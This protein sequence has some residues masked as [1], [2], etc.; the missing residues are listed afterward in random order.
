[1]TPASTS[2]NEGKQSPAEAAVPAP[3]AP[4]EEELKNRAK[5][6]LV[7]M[8][9]LLP[10]ASKAL[11]DITITSSMTV[12]EVVIAAVGKLTTSPAGNE[13]G[14]QN[15]ID[16]T[17][18][19]DEIQRAIKESQQSYQVE[20]DKREQNL[21]VQS[22]Q[23][24]PPNTKSNG[25]AQTSTEEENLNKAIQLSLQ[26]SSLRISPLCD[27]M[28]LSRKPNMPVGL[29][30]TGN[31]CYFNSIVQVLFNSHKGLRDAILDFPAEYRPLPSPRS[32]NVPNQGAA[33]PID[34][35]STREK[36]T[37][38]RR[39]QASEA[40]TP[41]GKD[42]QRAIQEKARSPNTGTDKDS[43]NEAKTKAAVAF[44]SELQRAFVYLIHSKRKFYDPRPAVNALL[45]FCQGSLKEGLQHDVAEIMR[46]IVE[47]LDIAFK[48]KDYMKDEIEKLFY[49]AGE[50][51]ITANDRKGKTDPTTKQD[52]KI[53]DVIVD[54]DA[55]E[56]HAALERYTVRAIEQFRLPDG[57]TLPARTEIW[58]KRIPEMLCI[59]INRAA[60][61]A[62][63]KQPTKLHT[64]FNFPKQLYMDRYLRNKKN[65]ASELR[66]EHARLLRQ[67]DNLNSEMREYTQYK[68]GNG[69]DSCGPL[70][71][72]EAVRATLHFIQKSG[73]GTLTETS[74]NQA[75]LQV[76]GSRASNGATSQT[77]DHK[78]N[79][80]TI[81]PKWISGGS[82]R[83][84][85]ANP[86]RQTPVIATL[87]DALKRIRNETEKLEK[88]IKDIEGCIETLYAPIESEPYELTA[89]MVHEGRNASQGHYWTYVDTDKCT[90]MPTPYFAKDGFGETEMVVEGSK[91]ISG[92]D[93]KK[94]GHSSSS[95]KE[96]SWIKFND[97]NV[98]K[99]NEEDVFNESFGGHLNASAYCLVYTSCASQYRVPGAKSDIKHHVDT[100][101]SS[102][103]R[104]TFTRYYE[105]V[106]K[107]NEDF[108]KS[109]ESSRKR[110]NPSTKVEAS[111]LRK[112]SDDS[113]TAQRATPEEKTQN[114]AKRRRLD[115]AGTADI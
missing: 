26:S 8:G 15:Q 38:P 49:A 72:D 32:S 68:F 1:M 101:W 111:N 64:K 31:I 59:Q 46:D 45:Q 36:T 76:E 65:K 37:P 61:D 20:Q 52:I 21:R 53:G 98:S 14:K 54:V 82:Q 4:N 24:P 96:S 55:S 77:L 16:M 13:S 110:S 19:E 79:E 109:T 88:Q 7:S 107:D 103:P 42:T 44:T 114:G 39:S 74:V 41:Q 57:T 106:R 94:P 78:S 30:N 50:E 51:I 93:E 66:K 35:I 95:Q 67:K 89:V 99:E 62:K 27:S 28:L 34:D 75:A 92:K 70:R 84:S 87:T 83:D 112:D 29:R 33:D 58:F 25:T 104:S 86:T 12:E 40:K 105:E 3:S 10:Q 69:K 63:K 43:K 23:P 9:F 17:A 102:Y 91:T 22:I 108:M 80:D 18:G 97:A 81:P 47:A 11:D 90:E 60:Y 73:P 100:K 56:L 85:I 113:M 6:N 2:T 71:I 5:K 48:A 115:L